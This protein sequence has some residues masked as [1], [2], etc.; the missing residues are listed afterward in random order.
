[1]AGICRV[2]DQ[3]AVRGH[4]RSS[5]NI[6]IVDEAWKRE[7]PAGKRI[8]DPVHVGPDLVDAVGVGRITLKTDPA[9]VGQRL[10]YVRGGVLIDSHSHPAPGLK[11]SEASIRAEVSCRCPII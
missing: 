6:P 11:L 8:R 4:Q 3:R 5:G 9:P 10:E 7:I 2:P 1:M